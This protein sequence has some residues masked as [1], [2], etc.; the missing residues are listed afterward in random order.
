MIIPCNTVCYVFTEELNKIYRGNL[1]KKG[2]KIHKSDFHSP[3]FCG[4]RMPAETYGV[5]EQVYPLSE[6]R[7]VLG[8]LSAFMIL[9]FMASGG[10]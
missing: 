9:V 4:L 5:S 1:K 8:C 7:G 10:G 2:K 3:K 6:V